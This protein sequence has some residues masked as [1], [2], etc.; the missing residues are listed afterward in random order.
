LRL[1]KRPLTVEFSQFCFESFHRDTDR[2]VVLKF[3]LI[4]PPENR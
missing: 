3:R 2:R 4:W 1:K